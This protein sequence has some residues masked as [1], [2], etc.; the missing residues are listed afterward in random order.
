VR[1]ASTQVRVRASAPVGARGP[2]PA[3]GVDSTPLEAPLPDHAL[4]ID[5]D[6]VLG[7]QLRRWLEPRGLLVE[8]RPT[9]AAGLAA[10]GADGGPYDLLLLDLS[11]PDMD[12][13]DLCRAARARGLRLPI[14][15]LTARG[16]TE[17]RVLGLELGAD[18]YLPKPFDPRELL[19]R[20]RALLRRARPAPGGRALRFGALRLDPDA[21]TA[22]R[23]G[24]L[25]P[26]TAHQHA[27]LWALASRAGR[28]LSRAQIAEL[29]DLGLDDAL[30][31]AVDVQISRIRALIEADPRQPRH[32]LTV[33]GVGYRF[34]PADGEG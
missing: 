12:G 1:G 23:D 31:R 30:D 34:S 27:I 14:L 7:D 10:L 26:L 25:L 18:D 15:M 22:H 11:L 17:D 4:L 33:R 20:A 16:D 21:G 29:V 13:L 5:D 9:A 32:L 3:C 6:R 8:Q 19:A 2:R 24:A 28:V